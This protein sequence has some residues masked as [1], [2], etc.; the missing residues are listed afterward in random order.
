MK[1]RL[2][3][4]TKFTALWA[5][6]AITLWLAFRCRGRLALFLATLVGSTAALVVLFEVVSRGRFS[7][8]LVEVLTPG[9]SASQGSALA[10]VSTFFELMVD[11]AGA[12]WLL[13]PF[14]V[15]AILLAAARRSFTLVELSWLC[16]LPIV[17]V[18]LGNPG[19]DFNHLIDIAV[20]TVL[21]AGGLWRSPAGQGQDRALMLSALLCVAVILGTL[22]SYRVALKGEVAHAARVAAGRTD[23][24][25]STHPLAGV[26]GPSDSVLSEDPVIPILRDERPIVLDGFGLRRLGESHPSL[27]ADLERR[28][29]RRA[30]DRVV[31]IHSVDDLDW[32][33]GI[34][35]GSVIRAAIARNYELVAKVKAPPHE[36]Y[37]VYGPRASGNEP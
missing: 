36:Y 1:G 26:V 15:L 35:M 13:F 19:S 12:I 17:V 30:F 3:V 22:Q 21:V 32:Y 16:A 7:D 6:I 28:L 37:W 11:R 23:T 4:M 29:D 18:V 5:P 10:G 14:A 31:L 25:Y 24:H 2:A 33:D 27:L 20:L 8:N 34:S 9:G